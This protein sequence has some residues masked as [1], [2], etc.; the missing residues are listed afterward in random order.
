MLRV[1]AWNRPAALVIGA[2]KPPANEPEPPRVLIGRNPPY[3]RGIAFWALGEVLRDA[4]GTPEEAPVAEVERSLQSLL[5]GLGAEDA[6]EIAASLARALGGAEDERDASA[7]EGLRRSWRRFV[8]LLAAERPLVIGIDDAHW[9]DDG[10]LDLL[11]EAVLGL[12]EAPL[13]LLCTSRPELMERR[14]DFGRA[15]GNVSQVELRPLDPAATTVLAER[16][17]PREARSLAPEVAE[18][19]GGNPFF[20]EEVSCA[21]REGNGGETIGALPD[22]VQATIAGRIDL[23]PVDEKRVLQHAAVLGHTFGD[24]RLGGLLGASPSAELTELARKALVVELMERG[25]G[26]F[27]FRHQLIRDVAYSSLPRSDR[28]RL[29]E[30]AAEE[31]H[32]HSGGRYAELA[33]LRAFHLAEAATLE[34]S[35]GRAERARHALLEAADF[36]VRRGAGGRGKDLYE[37]AAE[38]ASD[39]GD[40]AAILKTAAEIALRRWEGAEALRLL[41]ST[42]GICEETGDRAGAAGTYARMVEVATRM[43]GISGKVA[44]GEARSI[45]AKARALADKA[46]PMIAAQLRLNEAWIAWAESRE[47]EMADPAR[48]GLAMAREVGDPTLI[49]GALDAAQV[50]EWNAG[51]HLRAVHLAEERLELI[52]ANPSSPTLDVERSD[53]LHMMVESLLQTGAFREAAEFAADAKHLDL[54]RGIAYSAWEREMLPAFYLG[55][56][57]A[58]L[59]SVSQFRVEWAAAGQPPLAAMAASVATAG[60][61]HGCRG[62]ESA[63]EEWFAFGEQVAPDIS[64]QVHGIAIWRADVDLHHGRGSAAAERLS[65]TA[66]SSFWWR[67]IYHSARAEAFAR[68]GHPETAEAIDLARGFVGDNR[69]AKGLLGR[70]EGVHRG[71]PVLLAAALEQFEQ[72]ECPYQAARTGWLIG[73]EA[74]QRARAVFERLG[75]VEPAS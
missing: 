50:P 18:A 53:A 75:A 1:N 26:H 20:A 43:G 24:E 12:G 25:A 46:D 35:E 71:D 48:E 16:L 70:A 47:D 63:A 69:Y 15:V 30:R 11:E 59:E 29:H 8:G 19:S 4:A 13:L 55:E 23:L 41:R 67:T 66:T 33:E 45:Q 44:E 56:W 37:Q 61:I 9:A 54:N 6:G 21:L 73:G 40:R 38:L 22:T 51:R 42:A 3:G 34:R 57:D 64:G 36:A 10:L 31:I 28:V 39:P 58:V 65:E 68:A 52:D 49:S 72:I 2:W 27:A 74:R 17:L 14:P 62:D 7:E 60:A 32:E 5:A